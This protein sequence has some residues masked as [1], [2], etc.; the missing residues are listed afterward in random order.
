MNPFNPIVI[1]LS[2]RSIFDMNQL[3]IN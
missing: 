3:I 1:F 2:C